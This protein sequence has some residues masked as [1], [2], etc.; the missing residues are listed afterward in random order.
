MNQRIGE[1]QYVEVREDTGTNVNWVSPQ[2]VKDCNFPLLDGPDK[3]YFLDFKGDQYEAKQRVKIPFIGKKKKAEQTEF[4]IAPNSFPIDGLLV[5]NGFISSF[6]HPHNVFLDERDKVLVMVQKKTTVGE[7]LLRIPN[8][9][10][11]H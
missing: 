1:V 7:E 10:G 4:F 9:R 11:K 6:G 2:L 3:R 5:G 8:S